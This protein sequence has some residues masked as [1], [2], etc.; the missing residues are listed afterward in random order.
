MKKCLNQHWGKLEEVPKITFFVEPR[1]KLT[2]GSIFKQ[3]K[4]WSVGAEGLLLLCGGRCGWKM[5]LQAWIARI[6][7]LKKSLGGQ[8]GQW[9]K[10]L[11]RTVL[12]GLLRLLWPETALKPL[13]WGFDWF[14]G[15]NLGASKNSWFWVLLRKS[16]F[17]GFSRVVKN[18]FCKGCWAEFLQ[19]R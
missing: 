13:R 10:I 6:R 9:I 7:I 4:R 15:R 16:R 18:G 5:G 14:L 17:F 2:I 19:A 11:S 12:A 3:E 8:C 1:F